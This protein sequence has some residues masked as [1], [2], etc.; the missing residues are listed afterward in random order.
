MDALRIALVALALSGCAN[1]AAY[2][3][4]TL[5]SRRMSL[6]GDPDEVALE[7]TRIRTREEGR[8]SGA[9]GAGGN[10]GGGCGCN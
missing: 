3:R 9:G 4:E 2:E 10:G 1:I 6:D 8:L 5:A 7:Q